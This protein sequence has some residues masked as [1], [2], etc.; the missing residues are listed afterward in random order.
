MYEDEP[1]RGESKFF[2]LKMILFVLVMILVSQ[3]YIISKD[4]KAVNTQVKGLQTKIAPSMPP[5]EAKR[6]VQTNS[7]PSGEVEEVPFGFGVS[8]RVD[9]L[10]F[11]EHDV[12]KQGDTLAVLDKAPFEAALTGAKARLE[13]AM[14]QS[15]EFTQ[16]APNPNFKAIEEA[17]AA[18][19]D[20][21]YAYDNAAKE[22]AKYSATL[23]AG[24]EDNVH[25]DN[26]QNESDAMKKLE[27][28]KRMLDYQEAVGRALME[29]AGYKSAVTIAR[30][31]VEA[32]QYNLANARLVAT[33]NGVVA[34]INVE[35]GANVSSGAAVY[36]LLVSK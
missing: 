25:L 18:I 32:A 34:R 1:S 10:F 22:L 20:A 12:V 21:Q 4:R 23:K 16:Y 3:F 6:P 13:A 35:P 8:G 29:E 33:S 30:N 28:A 26:V 7:K 14:K 15:K 24:Q 11:S 36:T 31:G 27:A 17:K 5:E 19:D 2:F 9:K